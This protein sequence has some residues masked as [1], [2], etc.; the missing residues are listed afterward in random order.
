VNLTDELPLKYKTPDS[1][2]KTALA[3]LSALLSDHAYLERKA[4]SNAL[5]LLNRWPEPNCPDTWVTTL[6]SIARDEAL[7]L[8]AVTRLIKARGGK[9]ERLHRNPYVMA[10]HELIRSG[11]GP[12]EI[13]DR[14]LVSALIEARS[15]ER[16]DVLARNC[17]DAELAQFYRG[18]WSS[19]LGHYTVFLNL[20]GEILPKE[21][22]DQRWAWML[23]QEAKIMEKQ[24][25]GSKIHS[26]TLTLP[27]P[28]TGE[29]KN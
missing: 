29:G 7:H 19:E 10:L 28:Q 13:A 18:L 25:A 9:L 17:A 22:L 6:S 15:C 11:Q 14:L 26:G 12:R 3:D 16:F 27:S 20:A 8:N 4:A 24:P 21:E 1:W 5:L 23:E 2:A